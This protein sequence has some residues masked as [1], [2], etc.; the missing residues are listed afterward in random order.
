MAQLSKVQYVQYYTD[1][2]AA[3]KMAPK[4]PLK[5]AKLPRAKRQKRLTI[6]VDPLAIAG[7]A[8][9]LVMLVLM[10]IGVVQLRSAQAETVAMA[11]YV[12]SL[13][14]ENQLLQNTYTSGYELEEVERVA[15]ALGMVPEEQVQHITLPMP[16]VQLQEE[17]NGFNQFWSFLAGLFA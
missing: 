10:V 13:E 4:T 8:L 12:D 7:I 14:Q 3:R 16:A 9:A 11:K 2:S 5:T 15:L 6:Y 17:S 1:G